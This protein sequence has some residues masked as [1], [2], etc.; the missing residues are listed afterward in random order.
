MRSPF[1]RLQ[2]AQEATM[3]SQLDEPPFDLGIT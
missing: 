3:F 2:G 1:L